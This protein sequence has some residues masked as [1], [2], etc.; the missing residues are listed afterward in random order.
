MTAHPDPRRTAR[1]TPGTGLKDHEPQI[2]MGRLRAGRLARLREQVVAADVAAALL[3]DPV[4][5]RYATGTRNMQVYGQHNPDRYVLVPAEGPVVLFDGYRARDF[6]G[7][8]ETVDECRPATLFYFE[9]KGGRVD[10]SAAALVAEVAELV[11]AH[12]GGNRR[13]AVDRLWPPLLEPFAREG[14]LLADGQA[15][16]ER[17]RCVKSAEEI[18]CMSV[19]IA[20]CE[21]GMARMHEAA[22]P[23]M[24]E[25]QLWALLVHANAELGGEW[26]ETRLLAS[27]GRTNPWY[28]ECG[29]KL[30]RAGELI[31]Y[32]TDLIG[33]FGYCADISR[34]FHLGPGRPSDEQ[35]RLYRLAHEQI[36]HNIAALEPG[37]SFR[38]YAD[39]AW[40]I[41]EEFLANR[42]G[43]VAH[44][45]GLLDEY[46]DIAHLAD[47]A[48]T[49]HDGV[50]E[51][52]MTLCVESYIGAVGGTEGVKL[53]E[54]VLVTERG[55][56]RLSTFPFE[57]TLLG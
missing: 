7:F 16:A 3:F 14:L 22:R 6:T 1:R 33:P 20:V 24:S 36:E 57:E 52:G 48:E 46:P 5:I 25:Q 50:I 17:A 12:G 44:G 37:M 13:L 35:R 21:T 41:P 18:A 42:Y 2:D 56:Q 49:G 39:A 11:R 4:N 31:A 45:V 34:T 54:Q 29:E 53:E 55:V 28:Q 19:A 26:P 40:P 15:L 43:S 9:T 23:G 8:P 32:D 10:E 38:Q 30:L 27:G 51:P 47:W